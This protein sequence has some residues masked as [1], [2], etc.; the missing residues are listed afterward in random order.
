MAPPYRKSLISAKNV[1]ANMQKA[2]DIAYY[3]LK[4]AYPDKLV[5]ISNNTFVFDGEGIIGNNIARLLDY[6]VMNYVPDK[7]SNVDFIGLSYYGRIS[8]LPMPI[9]ALD[10]ASKL[11][12]LGRK[13][14]KLWEYYPHGLEENLIRMHKRYGKPLIITENGIC[15]DD[16]K[17]R[18][19][20]IIDHITSAFNAIMSGVDLKGYFHWSTFD[21]FELVLGN[22]YRYGLVEVDYSTMKRTPRKS[23][24]LYSKIA[25][26][27]GIG[28]SRR[29]W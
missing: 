9:T 22:S 6:L 3:A 13:H 8:S 19:K 11:D 27:N 15:T 14:D 20:G 7:F 2:H 16:D 24:E 29:I 5:G 17:F 1:L 26:A 23:A 21:N 18:V 25:K 10:N 28:T 4:S 12:S